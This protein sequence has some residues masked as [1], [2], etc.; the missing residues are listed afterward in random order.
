M[1]KEKKKLARYKYRV[2]RVS[3]GSEH[4]YIPQ[5]KNTVRW[6]GWFDNWYDLSYEPNERSYQHS[7]LET[8]EQLER[9]VD[10]MEKAQ[11][12]VKKHQNKVKSYNERCIRFNN[13]V[14]TTF[15]IE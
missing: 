5:Y 3:Y 14:I 2:I 9:K 7:H 15:D 11:S 8:K 10:S 6:W 13:R 12:A 4:Q 1:K